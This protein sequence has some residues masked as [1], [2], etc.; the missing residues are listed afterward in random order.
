M[1]PGAKNFKGIP[2]AILSIERESI[3]VKTNDSFIR[4]LEWSATPGLR[5]G[6]RLS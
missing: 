5:I 6:D 4:V 2:G 1:V 3:S